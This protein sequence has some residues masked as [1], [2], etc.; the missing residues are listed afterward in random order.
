MTRLGPRGTL[1]DC[2]TEY[3]L[4]Y[5]HFNE[6][7]VPLEFLAEADVR[8]V[9]TVAGNASPDQM[10]IVIHPINIGIELC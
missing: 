9:F 7:T 2:A 8:T 1:W 10:M 6:C 4:F 5:A 3:Q